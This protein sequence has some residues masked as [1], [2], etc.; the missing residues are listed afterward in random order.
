MAGEPRDSEAT[1]KKYMYW[2]MGAG[3]IP[4][5]VVDAAAVT[6]IQLNMVAE[7]ARE[8]EQDFSRE[9]GRAFVASLVCGGLPT[10]LAGPLAR[11]IKA[12]PLVGQ[13]AGALAMPALAGASTYAVGKVFVQHFESG[14]TFHDFDPEAARGKYAGHLGNARAAIGA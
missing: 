13:T 3:L 5:P 8:H 1:I 10:V 12:I 14:G 7:L 2:S 11:L 4:I 6:A 9:I